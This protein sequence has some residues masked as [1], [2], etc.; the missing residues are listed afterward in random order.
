MPASELH[1][2]ALL[3]EARLKA[4]LENLPVG[5]VTLDTGGNPLQWNQKFV[6]LRGLEPELSTWINALHP[7]DRERVVQSWRDAAVRG[8]PWNAV[9]RFLH[10]DGRV[11]WVSARAAPLRIDG[12][13]LG[14]VRTLEDISVLKTAEERLSVA[15]RKLQEQAGKLE[16]Q[17]QERTAKMQEA[18]AE[19]DPLSYSI[20]HDM[21]APL[22]AM[23]GF[24]E[25]VVENY[26]ERLDEQ[27]KDFLRRIAEASKRQD[28]LI[29][30]VLAYHRLVRGDFAIVPVNLDSILTGILRTYA[31]LQAPQVEILAQK[32]LGW[33]LAH[34]TL[35]TQTISALLNNAIKF[36]ADGVTPKVKIWSVKSAGEVTMWVK[37]NGIG[38]APEYHERIFNVFETLHDSRSYPGTGAGLPLARRA[39]QR[40]NGAIGVQ[41]E[42]GK[43][44]RFWIR[45][46]AVTR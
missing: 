36:V 13:L 30:G 24:S 28:E 18:L 4:V 10:A 32:P 41:S 3:S 23:Q 11:V 38:I 35:L 29:S 17:V 21:R 19:L 12:E 26:A 15:N 27:G 9:Y 44:S 6:E 1:R 14:F 20:V 5:V 39:L 46:P 42:F 31:N 34:D 7:D 16:K 22:R 33:V 43:G 45:L 40:M 8:E 37:D 25:L 2:T